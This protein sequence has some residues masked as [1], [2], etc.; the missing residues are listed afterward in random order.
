MYITLFCFP[1]W[2]EEL[3]DDQVEKIKLLQDFWIETDNFN[4]NMI[5][6]NFDSIK[7]EQ[8]YLF[9]KNPTD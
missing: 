8:H 5:C 3:T 4:S 6:S 7:V 2:Y 9:R 1:K